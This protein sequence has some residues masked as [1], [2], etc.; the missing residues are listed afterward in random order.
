MSPMHVTLKVGVK[1]IVIQE[2]VLFFPRRHGNEYC[3]L[4]GSY[5]GWD[6]PISDHG[7]GNGGK[8]RE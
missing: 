6:F 1:Q 4:I 3:N 5:R 8:Q 2:R 7:H